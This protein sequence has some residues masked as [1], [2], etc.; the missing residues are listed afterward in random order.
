MRWGGIAAAIICILFVGGIFYGY[1]EGI[2]PF[3]HLD[4][5]SYEVYDTA[6]N[7]GQDIWGFV[8]YAL[9][10]MFGVVPE[11][12][13]VSIGEPVTIGDI[14]FTVS[15]Y[16]IV[17][18][19]Y[20]AEGAEYLLIYFK[21]KNIGEVAHTLPYKYSITLSYKE[22]EVGPELDI[23]GVNYRVKYDPDEKIY[24]GVTK[25]GWIAYEVPKNIDL[26]DAIILANYRGNRARWSF[27]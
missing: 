14:V 19:S 13:S 21:A 23:R 10:T 25:E 2:Y 15:E 27:E 17:E 8:V 9:R 12:L 26:D 3:D 7:L 18:S 4:E 20:A 5:F 22:K 1:Q 24:P 6:K 16:E 11:N